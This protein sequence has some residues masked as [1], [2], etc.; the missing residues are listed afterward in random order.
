MYRRAKNQRTPVVNIDH[1]I[2]NTD[3]GTINIVQPEM[4]ATTQVLLRLIASWGLKLDVS[5]ASCLLTG[6]VTDTLCFRTSNVTPEVME[7]AAELMQAGANLSAITQQT[8]NRKPFNSVR[9]W[10]PLLKNIQLEDR[11]VWTYASAETRL[12][13]GY[14]FNGDASVASFLI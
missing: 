3:Y 14:R 7:V 10:G 11:V 1:H 12:K 4:A 13:A 6:L 5:L 9:Y 2:T 8:V